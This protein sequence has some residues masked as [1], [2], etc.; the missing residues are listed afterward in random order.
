MESELEQL[1]HQAQQAT[2]ANRTQALAAVVG[3]LMRSQL[4]GR[5]FKEEPQNGVYR[6]LREHLQQQILVAV[7]A[8][9]ERYQR[10]RDTVAEWSAAVQATALRETSAMTSSSSWR[11]KPSATLPVVPSGSTR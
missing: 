1:L 11:W 7:T 9:V 8:A 6:E 4:L 3:G 5:P 10:D 2:E